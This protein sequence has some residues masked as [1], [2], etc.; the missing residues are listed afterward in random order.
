MK[1]FPA[2]GDSQSGIGRTESTI[3]PGK[4]LVRA[5]TAALL[6][7]VVFYFYDRQSGRLGPQSK[8]NLA[9]ADAESL[10]SALEGYPAAWPP[11]YPTFL[12]TFNR[13]GLPVRYF[14]L[15]CFY[16]LLILIWVFVRD[17]RTGFGPGSAV[18]LLVF[19]H[20]NYVNS[21][22]Q[23]SETLFVLLAFIVL[24]V[25]DRYRQDP[26]MLL[27]LLTAVLTSIASLTRFFGIFW[28]API[29]VVQIAMA[30]GVGSRSER[31][32]HLVSYLTVSAM[33]II[34]W[35]LLL[36]S[37]TGYFFGMERFAPRQFAEQNAHWQGAT[38]FTTNIVF[39][40]KTILIDLFSPTR[41][42][43]HSVVEGR[44]LPAEY[45][46][47]LLVAI[48]LVWIAW[49]VGRELF[50]SERPACDS[51]KR[52]ITSHR[53]LPLYFA[54]GYLIALIVLW[55]V[56]NNDPIYSRFVFPCYVFSILSVFAL[57]SWVEKGAAALWTRMPFRALYLLCLSLNLV[58]IGRS[59]L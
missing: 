32:K 12:W 25:L 30:S 54:T 21:F 48:L 56:G 7:V 47:F 19:L 49:M 59:F 13:L 39:V 44:L 45:V 51:V 33:G 29:V 17:R 53:A 55:T 24:I 9:A 28:I 2:V 4:L 11:V 41:R 31:A 3:P 46:V 35:L 36:K 15:L 1:S 52:A 50:K 26:S 16:L 10:A 22:Q 58:K 40:C 43:R 14:N 38:D 37:R 6:L 5:M 34:P 8:A 20:T 57:F 27:V 23:V 18:I 42:A